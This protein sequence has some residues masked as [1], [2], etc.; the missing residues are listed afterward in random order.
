M[1]S[2]LCPEARQHHLGVEFSSVRGQ[3]FRPIAA[4]LHN[5]EHP[6]RGGPMSCLVLVVLVMPVF[7]QQLAAP[8]EPQP[9]TLRSL[10]ALPAVRDI[11]VPYELRMGP[12][13]A[14]AES[15]PDDFFV[16]RF[17]QDAFRGAFF[18]ADEYDRALELYRRRP[19][20]LLSRY[21]EARLL[22]NVQP[23][24]SKKTFEEIMA[25]QPG[26]VWPHLD[27]VE[28]ESLPGRRDPGPIE[29]HLKAFLRVC[30]E[31]PEAYRDFEFVRDP[32]RPTPPLRLRLFFG[33][34]ATDPGIR[35]IPSGCI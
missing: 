26:F 34:P 31:C 23:K 2:S 15:N 25:R 32:V 27:L 24:R 17:Y 6:R 12:V 33:Q 29:S 7:A 30:P 28:L 16:Q 19:D 13:R 21:F 35:L 9:S 11:S 8:C 22:M 5:C 20:H 1:S 14:L 3:A 10:E 18:L 4:F